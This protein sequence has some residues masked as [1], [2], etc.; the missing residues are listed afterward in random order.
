VLRPL[1]EG[2]FGQVYE[3]QD[4]SLDVSVALKVLKRRDAG[5]LRRFKDE[6]R[7]LRDISHPNLVTLHELH[8]RDGRYFFT[9]DLVRGVDALT[10]LGVRPAPHTSRVVTADPDDPAA[11]TAAPVASAPAR[12]ARALR[13]VLRQLAE[14]LAALHARGRLH[15]DIKPSNVLVTATGRV[16]ILDFGLV[17]ELSAGRSTVEV[18][19][20]GTPGYMA[21]ERLGRGVASASSDWYSV[22][23]MLHEA[24]T[25]AAPWQGVE[26]PAGDPLADLCARLLRPE[27]AERADGAEVLRCVAALDGAAAPAA[28]PVADAEVFVGREGELRTADAAV[29]RWRAGFPVGLRIFGPSGIGKSAFIAQVL[30]RLGDGDGEPLV[31]R[32]RCYVRESVPFKAVDGAVDALGRALER[33]PPARRREVLQG[34]AAALARLFPSLG[35]AVGAAE[36]SPEDTRDVDPSDLRRRGAQALRSLL[37]RLSETRRVALVLDD[38][39]WGDPD[40]AVLLDALFEGAVPPPLLLIV[41]HR[42]EAADQGELL[43][44]FLSRWPG[45]VGYERRDVAL[46]PLDGAERDAF[47]RAVLGDEGGATAV[48]RAIREAGDGHP[49]F[50]RQLSHALARDPGLAGAGPVRLD[51][52]MAE[53]LGRLSGAARSLLEAVAVA[54]APVDEGVAVETSGVG[55][56][57]VE[58]LG[59]L[60]AE[61][62]IEER[63]GARGT[64]LVTQHDWVHRSVVERLDPARR[65]ECHRHLAE[66]M[67]RREGSDVQAIADHFWEGGDRDRGGRYALRAADLA[68]GALAFDRASLL[69][70]RALES[71]PPG[72]PPVEIRKKLVE[73]LTRAGRSGAAGEQFAL[74]AGADAEAPAARQRYKRLAADHFL[75][76]GRKDEGLALIR[77]VMRAA[78]LRYSDSP[79]AALASLLWDRLV[80]AV[81]GLGY[82]ERAPADVPAEALERFDVL[83]SAM[84]GHALVDPI[85]SGELNSR[86]V[87][88]GLALGDPLRLVRCLAAEAAYSASLGGRARW[89]RCGALIDDISRLADRVESV[90]ARATV[91]STRGICAF[92]AGDFATTHDACHRSVGLVRGLPAVGTWEIVLT[93]CYSHT[94]LAWLG[95]Y[96]EL[97]DLSAALLREIDEKGDAFGSATLRV[98]VLNNALLAFDRP[99]EAERQSRQAMALWPRDEVT[100]QQYMNFLGEQDIRLYRGDA[101][102]AWGAFEAYLPRVRRAL[103]LT[104]GSVRV[105]VQWVR[106]RCA[107]AAARAGGAGE[108]W[109][110]PELLREAADAA[111]A[112]DREEAPQAAAMASAI[113]A[114]VAAARGRGEAAAL[115]G[116]AAARFAANHMQAHA[117]AARWAL[118][119]SPAELEA[120]GVRRPEAMRRVLLPVRIGGRGEPTWG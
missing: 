80:L 26:L 4:R 120:L 27:P 20:A 70:R 34:D 17:K 78:G 89:A 35:R 98:G 101:A 97:I 95:R 31:L 60:R 99:D 64:L 65:S 22:G 46:G 40:S 71:P 113:R 119:G 111:A 102:G 8:E 104:R 23:V 77:E 32:S 103:L 109:A 112:L 50:T 85:R 100:S 83:W 93:S 53:R 75:R 29:A 54:G 10:Y 18:E 55:D 76:A 11:P 117:A 21:P 74:L 16:V 106:G 48:G 86:A 66:A 1:G 61:R 108:R 82:R 36:A 92:F 90:E 116:D 13:G 39:H 12:D 52:L 110:P 47:V 87:R 51:G 79:R 56:A 63:P 9:L 59:A 49:F 68:S 91:E 15:L 62:L 24:L 14:G 7:A 81:R 37:A 44:H 33:L 57:V 3:V 69:Y 84:I 45:Y 96:R 5:E 43:A 58:V 94:A 118:S 28:A 25:G 41:S 38:L 107:L 6:F 2:G 114:G 42:S 72:E 67:A 115:L 19:G 30:G 105:E 73:A 88:M